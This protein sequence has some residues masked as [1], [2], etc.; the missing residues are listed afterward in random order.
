M[1]LLLRHLGM[2]GLSIVAMTACDNKVADPRP[3][4]ETAQ[5]RL[6]HGGAENAAL[7]LKVDGHLVVQNLAALGISDY[8]KVDAGTHAVEVT[9]SGTGQKLV[10]RSVTLEADKDYSLLVSGT[11]SDPE[12][13]FAADTAYIPL[14]GKAK[15]RVL[16]AAPNAPPLDVY[17]TAP[18]ADLSSATKLVEPFA[19]NLADTA[20]FP[21]FAERDP[22]MWQVR[23]TNDNT[24][25]VVLDTGPFAAGDGQIISVVLSDNPAGGIVAQ[26]IT[27]TPGQVPQTV[28][29]RVNHN[30]PAVPVVDVHITDPGADLSQ[31]HLFI[32]PFNYGADSSTVTFLLPTDNGT[33]KDLEVRFTEHNT[34]NVLAT[35]GT[36]TVPL[37]EGRR[38]TLQPGPGGGLIADVTVEP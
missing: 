38:V 18:G 21:G 19:Y 35:S 20:M 30:A 24:T 9:V 11:L 37:H 12:D 8:A 22:G 2:L 4:L 34:L 10:S 31:P 7:N 6:V 14:P 13:R 3:A 28:F 17:L 25:D 26:I 27:E 1:K 16:H 5:L 33:S 29:V 23:F 32:A 36:F 15:I